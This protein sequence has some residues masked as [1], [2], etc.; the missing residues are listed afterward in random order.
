MEQLALAA[1][2]P[3]SATPPTVDDMGVLDDSR[4]KDVEATARPEAGTP[5][6]VGVGGDEGSA[7]TS[8]C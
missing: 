8:V 5:M 1:I 3:G 2:V 7:M 4:D 6:R